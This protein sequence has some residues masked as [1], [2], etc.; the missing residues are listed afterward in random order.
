M[1]FGFRL[2]SAELFDQQLELQAQEEGFLF[3]SRSQLR[4]LRL[5]ADHG[6]EDPK[7]GFIQGGR[8][9]VIEYR[10]AVFRAVRS[11]TRCI[12]GD[13]AARQVGRLATSKEFT[14]LN[15]PAVLAYLRNKESVSVVNCQQWESGFLDLV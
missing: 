7:G 3:Q 12:L 13:T 11:I 15:E 8:I 9:N 5:N 14:Q 2:V 4:E 1:C 10:G 6:L